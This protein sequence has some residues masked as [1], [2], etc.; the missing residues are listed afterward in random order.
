MGNGRSWGKEGDGDGTDTEMTAVWSV[1]SPQ[2]IDVLCR[3]DVIEQAMALSTVL[4][5]KL[6]GGPLFGKTG[7]F[8]T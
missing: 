3:L 7:V 6:K 5:F 8:E 4:A 2:F 1:W